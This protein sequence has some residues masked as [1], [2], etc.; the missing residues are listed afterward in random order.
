[1][2]NKNL[3]VNV[4]Y[5]ELPDQPLITIT[6]ELPSVRITTHDG[7]AKFY[8][9]S[10]SQEVFLPTYIIQTIINRNDTL[11]DVENNFYFTN[12]YPRY[13]Y[14]D[15]KNREW[16]FIKPYIE[17]ELYKEKVKF[18]NQEIDK[19]KSKINRL[20]RL[21][22]YKPKRRIPTTYKRYKKKGTK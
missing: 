18:L 12:H 3:N 16:F 4:E 7:T 2:M 15:K 21:L 11:E 9:Q 6:M 20:S 22:K 13:T 17:N 19:Q 10:M 1:M 8:T 5:G 14:D